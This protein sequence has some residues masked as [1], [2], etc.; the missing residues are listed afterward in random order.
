MLSERIPFSRDL[1][2]QSGSPLHGALV[3]D[4][5][6]RLWAG[7]NDSF[8]EIDRLEMGERFVLSFSKSCLGDRTAKM[9]FDCTLASLM[10]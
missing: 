3:F 9:W 8:V 5:S 10:G 4:C 7:W 6:Y 2:S 1:K